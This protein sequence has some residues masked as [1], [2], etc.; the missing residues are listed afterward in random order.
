MGVGV[1]HP[2]L[3]LLLRGRRPGGVV[4]GADIDQ[5]GHLTRGQLGEKAVFRAASGDLTEWEQSSGIYNTDETDEELYQKALEEGATVTLYSISS[6]C[7]KVADAFMEKYP[8]LECVPFDISTNDLLEKVTKEYEAGAPTA[9]VVHIKDQDGSMYL[10]Y[11]ANKIFYNFKPADIFSH[12]IGRA[13][14]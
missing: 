13:H 6:R 5:V 3:E 10:E 2:H 1:V 4:G 7:T 12:K 14:V 9:D 11:V 8:G